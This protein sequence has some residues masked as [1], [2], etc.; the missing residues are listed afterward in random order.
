[1]KKSNLIL[2][3]LA[4]LAALPFSS[5][6]KGDID[7]VSLI[8]V[9]VSK[10]KWSFID[11]NG[12]TLFEN[13][14]KN[15]PTVVYNGVFSVEE[16][17]GLYTVYRVNNDNLDVVGSLEG[18]KSAGYLE[19]GLIPVAFPKE[20]VS[21]YDG[22][23]NKKFDVSPV[24]GHEVTEVAPGYR[25]GFLAFRTDEDK[26]GFLDKNG[27]VAIKPIYDHVSNF[28]AGRA[29]V[30]KTDDDGNDIVSVINTKGEPVYKIKP[31]Q[32]PV[33]QILN[34]CVIASEDDKSY[35]YDKDGKITKFSSKISDITL[36]DGKYVIFHNDDYEY[37]V[38]TMDGEILVRPK[39]QDI[40]F[41]N[42]NFFTLS[43]PG[44]SDG[45]LCQK[46]NDILLLNTK[47]EEVAVY[48]D[49]ES[50]LPAGKFGYFVKD[51][52]YWSLIDKDGKLK[53][54]DEFYDINFGLSTGYRVASDYAD[55]TTIT[56]KIAALFDGN[57][58]GKY[59]LG[60]SASTVLSGNSPSSYSYTSKAT[61]D[62]LTMSEKEFSMK[63]TGEFSETIA[64][65]NYS[66]YSS[67]YQWNTF[68]TL[69]DIEI[70]VT[71]LNLTWG[72]N[73]NDALASALQ[74][75]GYT[76]LKSGYIYGTEP[77][78]ALSNNNVGL[79]IIGSEH[80]FDIV[81]L[82]KNNYELSKEFERQ[83]SNISTTMNPDYEEAEIAEEAADWSVDT[84]A[85]GYDYFDYPAAEAVA[86]EVVSAAADGYD[87]LYDYDY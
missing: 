13:E 19:D 21:V 65:Y 46:D 64:S 45:F 59:T 6:N 55:Y 61:L 24:N 51:D 86:E 25:E 28:E 3:L 49:C 57:K 78:V 26:W 67:S 40:I 53:S 43:I 72:K 66:Y 32:R 85:V 10:D 8:P 7:K 48:E 27:N 15:M 11:R 50:L 44:T 81:V 47:G 54:K 5:C 63:A 42:V 69:L 52:K 33:M 16:K 70:R 34:G 73:G 71:D 80:S 77:C 84:V 22:N 56:K 29:L 82:D 20:R 87:Y 9:Q 60:S 38:A 1:M 14:F 68:S 39:Y 30:A 76:L 83:V 35:V 41:S 74:S 4:I 36:T 17:E 18:L 58:I 2:A 62:G 75:K 23:G 31:D 12:Q 79:L 37:G